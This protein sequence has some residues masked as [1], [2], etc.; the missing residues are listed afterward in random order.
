MKDRAL[1]QGEPHP[2]A[3]GALQLVSG[4]SHADI[5]R[6]KDTFMRHAA[7][8]SRQAEVCFDTLTK[9][10]EK[11]PVSDTEILGLAWAITQP[12]V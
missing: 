2:S 4:L 8:G 6:W 11:L 7:E 9:L 10:V 12:P 3:V 1:K 5:L